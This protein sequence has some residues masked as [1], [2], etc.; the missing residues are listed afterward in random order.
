MKKLILG[1]ILLTGLLS[2]NKDVVNV[3][4]LPTYTQYEYNDTGVVIGVSKK[5]VYPHN[6]LVEY[7]ITEHYDSL[8]I[9]LPKEYQPIGFLEINILYMYAVDKSGIAP[10]P[11]NRGD[12]C[13][14]KITRYKKINIFNNF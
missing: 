10:M 11:V 3:P 2:C 4:P 12:R 5:Y 9:Y 8:D 14:R 1:L 6:P 7:T 13:Y